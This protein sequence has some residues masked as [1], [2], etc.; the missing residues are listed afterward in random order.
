MRVA[1]E[2]PSGLLRAPEDASDNVYE[3]GIF[4]PETDISLEITV[5]PRLEHGLEK[6]RDFGMSRYFHL[7][8]SFPFWFRHVKAS[9]PR[10]GGEFLFQGTRHLSCEG[11][12]VA[13]HR[14]TPGPIVRGDDA[15]GR[16]RNP[17]CQVPVRSAYRELDVNC[18]DV[19]A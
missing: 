15:S 7:E 12:H 4:S 9:R 13:E 17:Q 18:R 14:D 3:I 19:R 10:N 1:F 11:H 2:A 5:I 8:L 16:E 6:R